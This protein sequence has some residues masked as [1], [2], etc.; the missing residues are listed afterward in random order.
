MPA[1][2]NI[3][4]NDGKGSP[5]T[6]T[7]APVS[8]DGSKGDLANRSASIPQGYETLDVKVTKPGSS[9]GAYRIDVNMTFPVVASVNGV[10]VVVRTSKFV[11]TLY[12]TAAGPEADRKDHRVLIANLFQNAL[13]TQVIE[14]LEPLY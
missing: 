4:I 9:T 6:H 5:Q 14:K 1:I 11:A 8:T 3:A 13:I 10:D 7:F 12:E 2:G